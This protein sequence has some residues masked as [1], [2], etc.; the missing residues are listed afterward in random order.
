MVIDFDS[1]TVILFGLIY[2]PIAVY[3]VKR[4]KI[5]GIGL[6]FSTVFY[7][8]LVGIASKTMFPIFLDESMRLSI[9]N[10][11][12]ERVNLIPLVGLTT[13]EIKFSVLNVLLFIPLGYLLPFVLSDNRLRRVMI[14]GF[15]F[16]SI[17]EFIQLIIGLSIG[18]SVRYV[19]VNDVIFNTLGCLMGYVVFVICGFVLSRLINRG[20]LSSNR[21]TDYVV[22]RVGRCRR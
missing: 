20:I 15:V 8:Y 10:N 9:G 5:G 14:I 16:S 12:W 21:V 7:A 3:L 18:F 17:I 6:L 2:V 4:R 11:V 13:D 1:S 22:A 19:D